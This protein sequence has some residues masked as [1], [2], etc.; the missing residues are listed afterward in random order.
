MLTVIGTLPDPHVPLIS[1]SVEHHSG[2]LK[3]DGR[4]EFPVQRGTS[5]LLAA[6][7]ETIK[8]LGNIMPRAILAGDSGKGDGSRQIYRYLVQNPE[9]LKTN[10]L[11]FHYLFPD[12]DWHGKILMALETVSPKPTLVADAGFMYVAKMSGHA[13][14]YD[15]FTPDVGELA[16]LADEEAPHPFYTRGFIIHQENNIPALIHRAYSH[17]NA[18]KNLLVKANRD[19]LVVNGQ[20]IE[21]VSEPDVPALEAIGGTGDTLTGIVS[22]LL[23]CGFELSRAMIVAAKANRIMGLLANPGIETPIAKLISHIREAINKAML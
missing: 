4:W 5:A 3:I 14:F 7:C 22:A 6:A 18:A 8:H 23:D 17:G 19:Y 15:L 16:F 13:S 1:G 9:S 12:V 21:T 10:V 2:I 20:I 11:V